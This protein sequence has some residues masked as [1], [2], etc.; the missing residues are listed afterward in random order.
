MH[1]AAPLVSSLHYSLNVQKGLNLAPFL[2]EVAPIVSSWAPPLLGV[3]AVVFL[4]LL[5]V[6]SRSRPLTP[7]SLAAWLSDTPLNLHFEALLKEDRQFRFSHKLKALKFSQL[8]KKPSEKLR[9]D[10]PSPTAD[11]TGS[12]CHRILLSGKYLLPGG[13]FLWILQSF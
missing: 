2:S 8:S 9:R 3:S 12:K 4:F 11:F 5:H 1:V 13:N 6:C 10:C 7:L